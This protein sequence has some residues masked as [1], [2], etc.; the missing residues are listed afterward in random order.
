MRC[1]RATRD[2]YCAEC[3]FYVT[4]SGRSCAQAH[5]D[6]KAARRRERSVR[7]LRKPSPDAPSPEGVNLGEGDH[8][9]D[10]L[11]ALREWMGTCKWDD[12]SERT[13]PT[14]LMLWQ[15][16]AWKLCLNDREEGRSC[17]VSSSCVLGALQ[18]LEEV[19]AEGTAEWRRSQPKPAGRKQRS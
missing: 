18:A 13:V 16:G 14:L 7:F 15:D 11:P 12:G 2:G 8:F 1:V 3:Y 10:E 9:W 4:S 5:S 19:L 6:R 17:W